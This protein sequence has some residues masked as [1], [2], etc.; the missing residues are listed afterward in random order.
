MGHFTIWLRELDTKNI[1]LEV[2]GELLN[3]V[4]QENGEDKMANK[5]TTEKVLESVEE[6]TTLINNV[7]CRK[8]NHIPR[9][10]CLLHYSIKGLMK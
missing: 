9:I 5:V 4:L 10:N 6:K 7:L 8:A 3:V 2:L 1:L